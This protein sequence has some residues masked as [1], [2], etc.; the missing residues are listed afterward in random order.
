MTLQ[1]RKG[2][3]PS[4]ELKEKAGA[5]AAILLSRPDVLELGADPGRPEPLVED[6]RAGGLWA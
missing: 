3:P 5:E 6:K 1:E 2:S 4:P